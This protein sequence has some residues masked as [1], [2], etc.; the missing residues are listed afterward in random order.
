M[1]LLSFVVE[2]IG[3]S[4]FGLGTKSKELEVTSIESV[5]KSPNFMGAK[6]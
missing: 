1:T 4:V 3:S 2:R 6:Y 5:N